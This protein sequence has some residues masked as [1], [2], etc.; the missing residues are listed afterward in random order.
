MR[1]LPPSG[2]IGLF[3]E[4]ARLGYWGW[5]VGAGTVMLIVA[6]LAVWIVSASWVDLQR[7]AQQLLVW[8]LRSDSE[9]PVVRAACLVATHSKSDGTPGLPLTHR[10]PRN[11][12][13]IWSEILNLESDQIAAA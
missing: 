6:P 8:V 4:A 3:D 12:M 9:A 10:R 13:S 5:P 7:P 1:A 11:G 2:T